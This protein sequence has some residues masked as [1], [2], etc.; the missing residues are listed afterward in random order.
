MAVTLLMTPQTEGGLE[1]PVTE[2]THVLPL[3]GEGGERGGVVKQS[4]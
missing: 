3:K 2:L 1:C 4:V